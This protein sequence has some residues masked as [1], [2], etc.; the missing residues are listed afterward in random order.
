MVRTGPAARAC[1][2]LYSGESLL[3]S[4]FG[5][6]PGAPGVV[7]GLTGAFAVGLDSEVRPAVGERAA[8]G[9]F[10]RFVLMRGS[11]WGRSR[12]SGAERAGKL[13][14]CSRKGTE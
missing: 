10:C 5:G 2:F 11:D 4:G 6:C 13:M 14:T 8:C 9:P 1:F 12:V 7:A 3:S